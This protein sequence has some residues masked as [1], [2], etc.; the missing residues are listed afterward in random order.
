[1][2]LTPAEQIAAALERMPAVQ[3]FPNEQAARHW[4]E[5]LA[6]GLLK[7]K[8]E[9]MDF[10]VEER[11]RM[12]PIEAGYLHAKDLGTRPRRQRIG[13]I[14]ALVEAVADAMFCEVVPL[15]GT[16]S[17]WLIGRHTDRL[18][19]MK[20]VG[21]LVPTA[22][23]L[24]QDA[25][26][27]EYH[28]KRKEGDVEAARGFKDSWLDAFV[29]GVKDTFEQPVAAL[30]PEDRAKLALAKQDVVEYMNENFLPTRGNRTERLKP[31]R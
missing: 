14:D 25:Y 5:Q 28:A 16:M 10:P 6:M 18:T 27:R 12:D 29:G 11:E 17:S 30:P 26:L 15:S 1:M 20:L 19:T 2:T 13:W 22:E 31:L 9:L 21:S 8:L 7:H 24:G 3:L 23:K 4:T